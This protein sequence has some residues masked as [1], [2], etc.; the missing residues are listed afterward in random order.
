MKALVLEKKQSLSLRDFP[1]EETV[2]PDEVRIQIKACGICGSDIHYYTHGAIG[3]FVVREPMILGHEAAG[4]ITELGSNVEGFKLGDRV[5]MEPGIPDLKSKETL[6]GNYNIDPKVRFWATPPIQG[7]LRESVVHPAMFCIKL[8]D[9]M[10]FAEGAMMEPLAIGMEAAKKARI[11]PGDTALVVGCG[12]IGIMVALSA[13]AAGCS[14]VFISDVKQPK[15]DIAAGYPNLIPINTIQENL[16]KAIS[17][18][19]G[20]YGVDRIFEASGYAPVY[21]DFLRCARPGCKV[22]LVGIP[23]EPVLIDVSFLQGRGISIETIFRY[24]NEFDKA[25]ALVSAG[26]IDV[27]RLI[28]KSFPFDKSI[29]AYQFAAANHPDVVKVMIEL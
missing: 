14:T 12:T 9:N 19:T 22:V 17:Q 20:G 24:V 3:D 21:P 28:S 27:K 11:E 15:L 7:C 18:Y 13:L 16:V 2:G 23:G 8:L 4:V 5:C 26:K 29:E 25:V 6:R 10:S 1:I